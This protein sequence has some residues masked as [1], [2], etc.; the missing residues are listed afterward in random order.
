M[1][2]SSICEFSLI[3]FMSS[4]NFDFSKCQ[5]FNRTQDWTQRLFL[6]LTFVILVFFKTSLNSIKFVSLIF[7]LG[8][9][10]LSF[11]YLVM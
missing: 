3:R 6:Y 11:F 7:V 2:L 10:V 4:E 8:N 9:C 5:N 1:Y